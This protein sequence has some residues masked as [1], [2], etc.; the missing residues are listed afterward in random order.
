MSELETR[1][2][3]FICNCSHCSL[4]ALRRG[5]YGR[6]GD[7]GRSYGRGHL[8]RRDGRDRSIMTARKSV[9]YGNRGVARVGGCF[10]GARAR[11]VESLADMVGLEL[12]VRGRV[13]PL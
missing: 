5:S 8:G 3:A 6:R 1:S 7:R 10:V 12:K 9:L 4:G 13:G 2:R 11:A